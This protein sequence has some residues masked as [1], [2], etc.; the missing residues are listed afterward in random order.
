MSEVPT[1]EF[2][3]PFVDGMR[4]R[5]AVSFFKY[6]PVADGFPSKVDA[7]ATLKRC[8]EKYAATGNTEYLMDAGNYAMIEFMHPRH[9]QAHF[10][11]TDSDESPGRM[12]AIGPT[13]SANR[14]MLLLDP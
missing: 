13:Q 3:E 10:R 7:I 4:K 1:T 2:C 5:M 11:A 8:L 6:G 12:G 14:N 9:P